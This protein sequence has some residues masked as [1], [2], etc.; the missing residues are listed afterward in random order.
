MVEMVE[1]V[2]RGSV[3]NDAGKVDVTVPVIG[4][5]AELTPSKYHADLGIKRAVPTAD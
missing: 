1:M 2:L 4:G 3:I 5:R